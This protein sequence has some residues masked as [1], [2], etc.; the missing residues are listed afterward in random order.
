MRSGIEVIIKRIKVIGVGFLSQ[1]T[2][3][4]VLNVAMLC[5]FSLWTAIK[6]NRNMLDVDCV[7]MVC[8]QDLA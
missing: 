7:A 3:Q 1:S 8:I 4:A 5:E 6:I 2:F